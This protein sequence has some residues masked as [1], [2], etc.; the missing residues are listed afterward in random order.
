M[1]SNQLSKIPIKWHKRI[2]NGSL[3]GGVMLFLF[4]LINFMAFGEIKTTK[5][6]GH[7][8]W[9][10]STVVFHSFDERVPYLIIAIVCLAIALLLF[11]VVLKLV[12][13]TGR[14]KKYVGM[15]K[16]V[17]R[18]E[19]QKL[20]DIANSSPKKVTDDLQNMIDAGYIKNYYIDYK[21]GILVNKN[22][23]PIQIKK[24][25]IKCKQC[26]AINELINNSNKCC[27]YCDSPL[28]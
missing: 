18:I 15:I 7:F 5:E 10:K 2:I 28:I 27:Q 25:K 1:L 21:V 19:I 6:T 9:K 17:D 8:F 24:N 23:K 3:Y 12:I 4:G 20:S 16:G 11:V 13:I 14:F 22:A 26:G